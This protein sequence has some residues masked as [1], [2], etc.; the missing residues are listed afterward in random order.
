MA[1]AS[2][3]RRAPFLLFVALCG[4]AT[5]A[6]SATARSVPLAERVVATAT[7]VVVPVRGRQGGTWVVTTPCGNTARLSTV[8]RLTQPVVVLDPGHGGD[9]KGASAADGL[10]EKTVNLAVAREAQAALERSGFPTLLTRTDD[11]RV[12]LAVRGAIVAAAKPRAFVSIHHN[13]EPD[14]S[15]PE[16]GT[17]V[18][19]QYGSADSKR[20]SGLIYDEVVRS[21]RTYEVAWV[22]D[23]DA[24]V[25]TRLNSR[26]DDYYGIVRRGGSVPT[27]LAELAFISNP[28][29]SA[30][31]Q[32][33]D[34]Q[35]AEGEAVARGI[36]RF[37]TTQDPGTGY[38]TAYPRTEP[39]GPGGGVGGC[40]DPPLG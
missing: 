16:P 1:L 17:E 2:P 12:P 13:S 4:A 14:G 40:I 28:A 37:L 34:V 35:R 9:E 38:V 11:Y 19:Y 18:Y 24:G 36:E 21:L 22:G 6:T 8:I 5:F 7:G 39:A 30:L 33:G 15:R 3:T 26:G 25:K 20:L 27:A 32:R 31:L 10:L 23:T 29:E